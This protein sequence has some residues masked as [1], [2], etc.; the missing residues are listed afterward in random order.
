MYMYSLD[1]AF[2]PYPIYVSIG[3]FICFY[4]RITLLLPILIIFVK[5]IGEKEN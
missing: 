5:I 3:Y 1:N 4:I 2:E